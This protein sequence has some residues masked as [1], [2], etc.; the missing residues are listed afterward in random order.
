MP[1]HRET[2][3]REGIDF[4]VTNRRGNIC[5]LVGTYRHSPTL[6]T[7]EVH[8]LRMKPAHPE[9]ADAGQ[10]IL[11]SPSESEWGRYAWTYLTLAAAQDQFDTLANQAG[12]IAA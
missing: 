6:H 5:L 11:C 10:L 12:G 1:K 2:Y 8:R 4:T 3:T 7:Y 9:S